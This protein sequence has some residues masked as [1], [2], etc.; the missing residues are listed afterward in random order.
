MCGACGRTSVPDPALDA[1]R[2]MRQHLIVASTINGI[3]KGMPGAPRVTA[4]KDGWLMAGPSGATRL[5]HT[6]EELWT[7]TIGCFADTQ[8]LSCLLARQQA[9]LADPDNAGL[10][11]RAAGIGRGLTAAAF[12]RPSNSQLRFVAEPCGLT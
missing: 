11:A 1:V 5:C 9:F 3:C 4:L 12:Q 8:H 10:A 6:V 2:T 7:A